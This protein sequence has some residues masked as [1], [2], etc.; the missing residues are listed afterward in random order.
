ML[1]KARQPDIDA[2]IAFLKALRPRG[3]W[4]LTALIPDGP[5]RS[6]SFTDL[7]KA[8][9]WIEKHAASANI[10]YTPN[11]ASTPSGRDGRVRKLD[12]EA[13]E[14]LHGD[15]DLD[16]LPADHDL[17]DLSIGERKEAVVKDLQ[18]FQ[19]AGDERCAWWTGC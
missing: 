1:D 14:F 11:P 5:V 15:Y 10:H 3:P 13:I 2:A 16:K 4:N 9:A 6:G 12:I 19:F 17:A 18:V 7:K 8:R